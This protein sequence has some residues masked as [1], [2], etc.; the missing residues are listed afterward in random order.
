MFNVDENRSFL[1]VSFF[2]REFDFTSSFATLI[3]FPDKV[4]YKIKKLFSFVRL[5]RKMWNVGSRYLY[6]VSRVYYTL[7]IDG[8]VFPVQTC[9][10]S[11]NRINLITAQRKNITCMH[12]TR[13]YGMRN[14]HAIHKSENKNG[15]EPVM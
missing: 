14:D 12:R 5:Y 11:L 7:N 3:I 4:R 1:R 6:K 2:D 8:I 13:D 15:R 9:N 10:G